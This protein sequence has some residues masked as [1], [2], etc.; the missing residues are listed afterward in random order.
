MTEPLDAA[1]PQR[2]GFIRVGGRPIVQH[3][4]DL[5]LSIGCERVI[6]I[7]R[8]LDADVLALQH[9]A[10]GSGKQFHVV[11]SP[12]QLS[13][14][15]TATDELVVISE[16]LLVDPERAGP[17]LDSGMGVFVQPVES[18]LAAGFERL[19]IN[20]AAAGLLRIPG[21]LVETLVQ[22]PQDCD[23]PS[24]LTRIALQA[25]VPKREVPAEARGGTRWQMIASDAEAH[26]IERDW[27]AD[28][29]GNARRISPGRW[30]ARSG[31]LAFGT[32]LLHAGHASTVLAAAMLA[33]MTIAFGL[34]WLEL[35][36]TALLVCAVAWIV[37]RAALLLRR[38]ELPRTI[39]EGQGVRHFSALE[40]LLDAEIVL[41]ILWSCKA[42]AGEALALRLFA[43]VV[44]MLTVRHVAQLRERVGSAWMGDRALLCLA[45][46]LV[47]VLGAMDWFLRIGTVALALAAIAVSRERRG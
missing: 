16:G 32:S 13:G 45:L 31:V 22:L 41:L 30:L 39:G 5:A 34:G 42:L 2:R 4:L 14:L 6:A 28:Q 24:A 23:I 38:I 36:A 21:R 27:I 19:D 12:A 35:P 46:A 7:A 18:G 3:Q 47:T 20:H 8:S 9:L 29:M 44:F 43:P 37:L 15:V 17:L 26:A 25:G 1:L 10:E 11:H 33:A 40:W